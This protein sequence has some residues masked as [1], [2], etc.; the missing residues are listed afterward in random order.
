MIQEAW[1][2]FWFFGPFIVMLFII[3]LYYALVTYNLI[4]VL[5]A[6]ELLIKAVTLLIVVVGYVSAH[7]ALAQAL[8]ITMIVIEVVVMVVAMGV[9]IGV[10]GHT[11]SLDTIKVSDLKG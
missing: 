5:I 8:V 9:V 1:R 11:G 7:T 6:L 10:R 4:R 2:L 3:G